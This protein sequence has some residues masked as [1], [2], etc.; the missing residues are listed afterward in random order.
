MILARFEIIL[1][2][3]VITIEYQRLVASKI[4]Y[5]INK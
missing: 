5:Y 2:L 4:N 3:N 1:S